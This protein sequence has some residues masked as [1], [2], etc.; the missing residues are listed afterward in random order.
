MRVGGS[1][2]RATICAL[3]G[4]VDSAALYG[5]LAETEPDPKVAEVYRRLAAVEEGHAFFWQQ[6]LHKAGADYY[7]ARPGFRARVLGWLAGDNDGIVEPNI[8]PGQKYAAFNL[9][10]LA[11]MVGT[12]LMPDLSNHVLMVEEISEY[13]YAC[14]PGKWR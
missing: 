6:Q 7:S 8:E 5:V 3:A 14:T 12:P 13:L 10:T 1:K 9:T 11:M 2:A 4:E